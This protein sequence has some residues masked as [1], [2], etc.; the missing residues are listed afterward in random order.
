[1]AIRVFHAPISLQH[2]PIGLEH[3]PIGLLRLLRR[4]LQNAIG[5]LLRF[6]QL[7]Q[8]APNLLCRCSHDQCPRVEAAIETRN[9]I[10]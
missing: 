6:S 1:M 10:H 3:T 9:R 2:T 4:F 8:Q 5:F 7:A